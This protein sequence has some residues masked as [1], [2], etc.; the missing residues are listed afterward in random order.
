MRSGS[1]GCVRP[2]GMPTRLVA[3]AALALTA[4]C[5]GRRTAAPPAV[6]YFGA[7]ASAR[8]DSTRP[9]SAAVRTGDFL[10]VSGTLGTDAA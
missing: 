6:A 4:A 1:D 9:F 8:F 3:V 5:A 10:F 7:D 2:P